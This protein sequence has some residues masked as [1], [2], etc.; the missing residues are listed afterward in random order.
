MTPGFNVG[1]T[2]RYLSTGSCIQSAYCCPCRLPPWNCI[3]LFAFA[4]IKWA[5]RAQT[6]PAPYMSGSSSKKAFHVKWAYEACARAIVASSGRARKTVR[7]PLRKPTLIWARMTVWAVMPAQVVTPLETMESGIQRPNCWHGANWL[8]SFRLC[9]TTKLDL[10][11]ME[12]T[13]FSQPVYRSNV[14]DSMRV[15]TEH[16]KKQGG[17]ASLRSLMGD[18]FTEIP[19]CYGHSTQ[20]TQKDLLSIPNANHLLSLIS[21]SHMLENRWKQKASCLP[22]PAQATSTLAGCERPAW[23]RNGKRRHDGHLKITRM[24]W[25]I[26]TWWKRSHEGLRGASR[27]TFVSHLFAK[28]HRTLW[29]GFCWFG[30]LRFVLVCV[31]LFCRGM[32]LWKFCCTQ[33]V[34][35]HFM[36]PV[37]DRL[38]FAL[39]RQ[40]R[41]KKAS[42]LR[43][44]KQNKPN[45]KQNQNTTRRHPENWVRHYAFRKEILRPL[46]TSSR[47]HSN[48]W[49]V[50]LTKAFSCC[51]SIPR[52][53]RPY[54]LA[55]ENKERTLR[56]VGCCILYKVSLLL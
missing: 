31:G 15:S 20:S 28:F 39:A 38:C 21:Y 35:V 1:R 37:V 40:C 43:T 17:S 33:L 4:S 16:P 3:L 18:E 41:T 53:L 49:C 34:P 26:T 44:S 42:C 36:F 32:A 2:V 9:R 23:A 27:F 10:A 22:L 24:A 56:E 11:C 13:A 25:R 48:T 54:G 55:F 6:C 12:N 19:T 29:V 50:R 14:L 30:G 47:W 51:F 5:R 46:S 52:Q 8:I 45:Q 7:P